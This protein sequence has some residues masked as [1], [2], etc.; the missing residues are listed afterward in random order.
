MFEK[1]FNIMFV[2]SEVK[3]RHGSLPVCELVKSRGAI[4]NEVAVDNKSI[5]ELFSKLKGLNTKERQFFNACV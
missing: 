5:D 2:R 1:L 4:I 3:K